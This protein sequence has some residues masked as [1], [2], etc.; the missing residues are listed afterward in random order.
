MKILMKSLPSRI[1]SGW[2]LLA[3]LEQRHVYGMLDQKRVHWPCRLDG[4][5]VQTCFSG[6]V[7][8]CIFLY[9]DDIY[10]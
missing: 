1:C 9:K 8:S 5:S 2:L 6:I 10:S 7:A 3:K 4:R